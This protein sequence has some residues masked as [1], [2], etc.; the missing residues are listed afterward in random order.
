M[1]IKNRNIFRISRFILLKIP[2][3]F[4]LLSRYRKPAKR[5]LI[6]KIDAIGDYILFRNFIE[7][8]HI[9]EKFKNYE[10]DI[11]GNELWKDIALKYDSQFVTRFFF[12]NSDQLYNTPVM[13]LKLGWTLFLRSYEKVLQP[14]YSR[15]LLAN[16]LAGLACAKDTIAFES[17]KELNSRYKSKTDKFYSKRIL[18]PNSIDHEFERNRYFFEKVTASDLPISKP[19]FPVYKDVEKSILIFPG[20]GLAKRNWEKEK[21][22]AIIK[23]ILQYT[24]YSITICGSKND[25][26][27]ADFLIRHVASHRLVNQVGKTSLADAIAEIANAQLV[28]TNETSAVHIANACNTPSICVQGGG[29]YNRFTPYPPNAELT[30]VCVSQTMPC[31]NC[32]WQCIMP[33]EED[34]PFPCISQISS[35]TVWKEVLKLIGYK[36]EIN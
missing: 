6:I 15:T 1:N 14:T 9:S 13:I 26:A 3:L 22:M 31:F 4:A 21:F 23:N 30:P 34:R 27:I 25:T 5:I 19:H 10:I 36:L 17:D 8:I 11:V 35:D 29:H 12:I 24:T 28:I 2:Y 7:L 32:D 20:S 18:L 33:Q 16:G